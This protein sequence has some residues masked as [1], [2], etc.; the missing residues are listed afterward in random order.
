MLK[1]GGIGIVISEK[2]NPFW[3]DILLN[4]SE[5][6]TIKDEQKKKYY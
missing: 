6:L 3:K 4:L 1:K 2:L 5:L